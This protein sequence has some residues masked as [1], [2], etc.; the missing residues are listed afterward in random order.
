MTMDK[1]DRFQLDVRIGKLLG[2]K[3]FHYT[4]LD[5]PYVLNSLM[6]LEQWR[7]SAEWRQGGPV[8]TRYGVGLSPVDQTVAPKTYSATCRGASAKGETYLIAGLKAI[9]AA[10]DRDSFTETDQP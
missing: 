2:K 10:E 7:P 8:L 5:A 6:L 1:Y 3:F 4:E 9:L